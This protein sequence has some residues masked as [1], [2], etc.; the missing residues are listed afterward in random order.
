LEDF[1]VIHHG[2]G[3]VGV[4]LGWVGDCGLGGCC[5]HF[6]MSCF[7]VLIMWPASAFSAFYCGSM[8][9][10]SIAGAAFR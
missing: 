9:W 6:C 4:G 8:F 7:H 1:T 5:G 10:F 2:A 3:R